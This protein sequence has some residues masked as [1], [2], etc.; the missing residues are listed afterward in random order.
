MIGL[1]AAIIVWLSIIGS[2]FL[3]FGLLFKFGSLK[4]VE[5]IKA[6][7]DKERSDSNDTP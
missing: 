2:A 4:E 7:M 5:E 6:A 1:L 3:V